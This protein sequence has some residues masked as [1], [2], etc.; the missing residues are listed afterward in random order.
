MQLV[1][2]DIQ[3]ERS[4]NQMPEL[5]KVCQKST[6]IRLASFS[7]LIRR[8]IVRVRT[9]TRTLPSSSVVPS[10]YKSSQQLFASLIRN[11]DAGVNSGRI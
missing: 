10:L 4:G 3:Q 9:V 11:F 5:P 7:T 2:V 6:F 8:I 1:H